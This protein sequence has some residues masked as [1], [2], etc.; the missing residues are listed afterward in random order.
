M[1]DVVVDCLILNVVE[2]VVAVVELL[3]VCSLPSLLRI[4][5]KVGLRQNNRVLRQDCL[6]PFPLPPSPFRLSPFSPIL[7][8]PS[9]FFL[10]DP[11]SSY[12]PRILVPEIFKN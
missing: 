2:V 9:L 3:R 7:N 4:N 12:S 1:F 8:Y 10:D 6:P 5:P 11:P